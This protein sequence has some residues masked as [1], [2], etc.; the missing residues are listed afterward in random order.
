MYARVWRA[1][2]LPG[3][4]HEFEA[5]M[6]SVRPLLRGL[7]GFCGLILLRTGPGEALETTVISMWASIEELRG[8]ETPAYAEAVVRVLSFCERR[9]LMREEEV[10]FSDFAENN[11]SDTATGF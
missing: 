10:V 5:A 6:N 9:P 11:L 3:K 4:V 2:I 7:P 8:S 1:A